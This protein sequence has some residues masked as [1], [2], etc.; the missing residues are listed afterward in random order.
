MIDRLEISGCASYGDAIEMMDE[1]REIN[2]VYGPNGAG[3]TTVSRLIADGSPFSKCAVH[4]Q[5]GT[6]LDT[7]VYNRDFVAKNFNQPGE[8][9]GIFTLG[10]KDIETQN[11]IAQAKL[12]SADFTRKIEN[13]THTLQGDDGTRGK[14]GELTQLEANFRDACWE[15]KKRHDTKL[16][17]ALTG[18]RGDKLKFKNR[19]IT[20]CQKKA[21]APLPTQSD[22]EARSASLF[23]TTPTVESLLTTINDAQF[24]AW[25]SDPILAKRVIGKSD[26]DIAAMILRLGNSDWVKQGIAY[27]GVNDG[28]CPFC[29]Q[30][31]PQSLAASLEQYFDETFAQDTSAIAVLKDGYL[32]AGERISQMVDAVVATASRFLDADALKTEKQVFDARFQ[33]NRQRLDQKAKEPSQSITLEPLKDILQKMKD[34]IETANRSIRDH[35]AMVANLE[36][37]QTQL[38]TDVWAFLAHSEITAEFA[39]YQRDKK[40]VDT[41]ISSL[42]QQIEKATFDRKAKDAEIRNLEKQTTSVRPTVDEINK[43]LNAFGFRSFSLEATNTNLY[44]LRR[45][46]G[47]DAKET[48]SEGERSFITFLYFYHLLKGSESSSGVT[49]DRVVVFDDPVSS[50]D[51]DVLFIVGSLIRQILEEVRANRSHIKQV[52]ILTHNV[53]FHKEI[54]FHKDRSAG[55]AFKEE[56]FWIIRKVDGKSKILKYT[57]NPIKTSYD[58]LWSEVRN[59]SPQAPGV[60]NAMR[61]ILEHYFRILGGIGYDEILDLFDGEE[62]L[63]C[64]ALFSWVN[65]GSHS[66]PDDIFTTLDDSAVQKQREVF[67]NIFVRTNH[68]NHYNMMMGEPFVIESKRTG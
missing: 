62:K 23:E 47:S 29:Q 41:A 10:Q 5:R 59:G 12:D 34:L 21:P 60:Q 19:L 63:I 15:V 33:T 18:Y 26:V 3:K 67:K 64:K 58:L 22:L 38:I 45:P 6:K 44:R 68:L 53:Y 11:K 43:L 20:E 1:L 50:L 17:G 36:S 14:R 46:D 57:I 39:K 4:W 2:F 40:S 52:F 30:K 25:E 49:T 51:S 27:Y 16:Q 9:K 28:D 35:N 48:L 54:T 24:L 31:A 13:L 42:E 61:R 8:L 7:F 56:T 32:L 55:Q 66:I 65:D 37:A